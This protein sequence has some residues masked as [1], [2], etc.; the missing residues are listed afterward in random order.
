MKIAV[1]GQFY[2]NSTS[3][4]IARLFAFLNQNNIQVVI[5]EKFAAILIE[6][7][8]IANT[9]QKFSSHKDLDKSFEM[10]ISVGG[11]GTFLRA[12]TLVRNSGIPILGINAGRLGF[13]AT[14]Q[15]ENIETFLQL[16]LE[17]KYT[18]SKRTL[19]SLKCA[20]KIEEI[21]DLNFAMNE[22]T[23]SRK[24]TTSMITIETYL[25]GEYLNSYW[26]DG[27]IIST[28]T[29]STGYSMS[30]GGPILTP[31]ANCLVITPIAPHNLNAR[32]LVIPDNTEIK[33]KVSGREENYLVSLDSRIASVKNEDILTIKK[34]PFKIN[35]IEIPE[36]TFLKTLR[37]K[38]LWGED[39]RN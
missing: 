26:A 33:L 24:D 17:K 18:I 29:G 12:T 5:E 36:E 10:L 2:Q 22:I 21:K 15:Q 1:F 9:Y 39:K 34:T 4:I 3:P 6:N 14:V 37:N 31:E 16:V 13:L 23:V 32:P 11:D 25:N 19:L 30:C 28:P 7:K 8:S 27:L 35:M 38:L 20:S